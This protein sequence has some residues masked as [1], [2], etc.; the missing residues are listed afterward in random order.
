MSNVLSDEKKQQVIALGKLGW[1]LRRIEQATGARFYFAT[2][3][4]AWERGTCENTNGLIRQYL[5]KRASMRRVSQ[6]DCSRIAQKLNDRPRKRLGY[7]TPAECYEL[8]NT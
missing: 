8:Q 6:L 4:H 5:P 7:L 2:P 1:T 3:H